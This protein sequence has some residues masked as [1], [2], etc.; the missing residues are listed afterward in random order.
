MKTT[1]DACGLQWVDHGMGWMPLGIPQDYIPARRP[2]PTPQIGP[3]HPSLL[4]QP[5]PPCP[6]GQQWA[7]SPT[8]TGHRV[9]CLPSRGGVRELPGPVPMV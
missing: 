1:A 7:F 6:S 8:L 3:T 5:L 2:G 9:C 4:C